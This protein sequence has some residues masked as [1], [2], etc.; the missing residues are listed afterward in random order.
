MTHLEWVFINVLGKDG[1]F[2]HLPGEAC[3]ALRTGE[4][5]TIRFSDRQWTGWKDHPLLPDLIRVERGEQPLFPVNLFYL[6][7]WQEIER[8]F[9]DLKRGWGYLNLHDGSVAHVTVSEIRIGRMRDGKWVHMMFGKIAAIKRRFPPERITRLSHLI[10]EELHRA[11]RDDPAEIVRI[12]GY[13]KHELVP[14]P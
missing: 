6:A 1:R 5:N 11:R 8:A 12:G 9:P 2:V 13:L 10:E 4:A 7:D 3:E 14:Y